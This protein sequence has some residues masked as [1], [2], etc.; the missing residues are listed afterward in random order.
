MTGVTTG[1]TASILAAVGCWQRSGQQRGQGQTRPE[2]SKGMELTVGLLAE[3]AAVVPSPRAIFTAASAA[4]RAC[5]WM[6][7]RSESAVRVAE[8]A[9]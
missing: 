4:Q 2:M 3:G 7:A 9:A 5:D 1:P 6:I 8:V